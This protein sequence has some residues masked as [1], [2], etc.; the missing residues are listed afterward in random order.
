MPGKYHMAL[1]MIVCRYRGLFE[2]MAYVE[3]AEFTSR[4]FQSPLNVAVTPATALPRS[5][6]EF[7]AIQPL[8]HPIS[9]VRNFR[10]CSVII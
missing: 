6:L 9:R 5:V 8:Q 7:I 1:F 10:V 2:F 4:L 3:A